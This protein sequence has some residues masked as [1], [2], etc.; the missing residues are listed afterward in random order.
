M[1]CYV[2]CGK[3]I[4]QEEVF[5]AKAKQKFKAGDQVVLVKN[6]NNAPF[7]IG[8]VLTIR[9]QSQPGYY[10]V[11]EAGNCQIHVGDLELQKNQF[12]RTVL[13]AAVAEAEVAMEKLKTKLAYLDEIGHEESTEKEFIVYQTLTHIENG[14]LNKV[15]KAKK[16]AELIQS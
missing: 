15:E 1:L 12:T 5:M 16:I 4:H 11:E 14:N 2:R 9:V 3:V 10:H 6:T 13:T 8:T 7:P